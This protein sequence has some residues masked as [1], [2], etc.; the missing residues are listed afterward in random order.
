MPVEPLPIF[1]YF[2]KQRFSQFG[3]GDCANWYG[4]QVQGA[5][6]GQALYP[7][8]G[9][10]HFEYFGQ[11][12]LVFNTQPKQ[13]FKTIDYMYVIEGTRVI[14]VDRFYNEK[15]IGNIPLGKETW[16][17]YITVGNLV[18]AGL[19]A[20]TVMYIITEDG[21]NVTMQQVTDGN[22]PQKPQ[23]I[24]AFGD[25]LVV[26]N[27]GT[28]D[29]HVSAINLGG[30][31]LD[32]ATC[33]T[34]NGIALVNRATGIIVGMA[35]LH[36]QMYIYN[37]Y[38]CDIW[39]NI[40]NQITAG[41]DTFEFPFKLNTSYNFD[42]GLY[43]PHTLSEGFGMM[44]FL[45]N[46]ADGLTSFMMSNG[47]QPVDI[48][49]QAVNVLLEN[50]KEDDILSP[51]LKG[52]AQGFLYQWENTIFYRVSAGPFIGYQE[53][54]INNKAMAIEYNFSTKKWSRV[55]EL[56]GEACRVRK[57]VYFDNKH[58]VTV[59]GDPA[60]Y[61]FGGN[62][63]RNELRTP[64]TNPQDA[65]AFTKYPMRYELATEQIFQEDYAE[66]ITDYVEIDF[67]F[68]NK[69]FFKNNAPFDNT[70]FIIAED[71]AP[72][73]SPVYLIAE[74]QISGEDVFL[75]M[76]QGN[77]PG[78]DDNH[79]NKYFKPFLAL[80]Y[81]DDGG[82]T[83]KYQRPKEF[84]PLGKYEWRMRWYNMGTSRNRS[85]QLIAVSSAPIVVLGGVH[86]VRR[87][88]GGAN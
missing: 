53:L 25:S 77:T 22:A 4:I 6:K 21:T 66:F 48:S 12:K 82:E 10:K 36:N 51:F 35:V 80:L 34:E 63:Y 8:M 9:R 41:G 13:A 58:F 76:E 2:N 85:Y 42:Y 28:P 23:Y 59:E 16:F 74:D 65:N 47:G 11:N 7:A 86:N 62:I 87:A 3:C 60:M 75:I 78:F 88:S 5:K 29:F 45:A 49:S 57:H 50:S 43:D 19:T 69:T 61:Q 17:D 68:G 83:Y 18:Y 20:E 67:V 31:P 39:A 15:L 55:I 32:P 37:N 79:Y 46:N 30:V 27:K 33:F 26:S 40:P 71:A 81:S 38:S 70:I 44:V 24:C 72:D 54:D 64:D 73:G 52:D 14:Q 1:S 56:N 84:S